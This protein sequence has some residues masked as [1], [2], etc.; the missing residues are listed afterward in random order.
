MMTEI[1]KA[2]PKAVSTAAEVLARG[3]VIIYPTE[4]LYG[5]GVDATNSEAM[6]KLIEMKKRK[7]EKT[8]QILVA[9]SDIA[10]AKKYL[11]ITKEA[12]ILAKR[13]MPG[14]LS[15]VLRD[16]QGNR[17]RLRIPER[18][19][20]LGIIKKFGGPIT[21]TSANISGEENIYKISD[22]IKKFGGKVDLII[23]DGNIPRRKASTVFDMETMKIL[24]EG[25]ISK[26]QIE[27]ALKLV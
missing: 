4:T 3:G 10:M 7:G 12:D 1:I 2:G 20:T 18:K 21:S 22:I 14:P 27:D 19:I 6:S 13:F 8:E 15:L 24:R 23:D 26:K 11:T 9:Y 16:K 17:A 25:P 5:I